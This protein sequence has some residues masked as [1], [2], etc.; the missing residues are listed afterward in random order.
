MAQAAQAGATVAQ[1][2]HLQIAKPNA[3]QWLV[4]WVVLLAILALLNRSRVGHAL[5]YYGMLL[6]LV[7]LVLTNWRFIVSALSPINLLGGPA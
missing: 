3:Y 1:Q 2:T 6:L 4:A 5:L 7:T